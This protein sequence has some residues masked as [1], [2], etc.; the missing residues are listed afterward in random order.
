MASDLTWDMPLLG[1]GTVRELRYS[2]HCEDG[3]HPSN[4]VVAVVAA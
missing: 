4:D 3:H 2:G 1:N